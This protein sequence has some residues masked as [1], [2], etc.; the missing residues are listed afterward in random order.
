M[1]PKPTRIVLHPGFIKF[2]VS[3]MLATLVG[4]FAAVFFLQPWFHQGMALLDVSQRGLDATGTVIG[5]LM[6]YGAVAAATVLYGPFSRQEVVD[7][8]DSLTIDGERWSPDRVR[9]LASEREALAAART[10]LE[11]RMAAIAAELGKVPQV[12]E[13][14]RRQIAGAV[15]FTEES[16]S[17]VLQRLTAINTKTT[18]LTHFLLSSGAESDAIIQSARDRVQVNHTFVAQMER[19]VGAR[20]AEIEATREQFEQIMENSRAFGG[21]LKAIEIIAHQTNL[22]A[23]NAAIEA[24]RAGEAGK[25]FAVVA[26]EVR[27]LSHQ[28]AE[29]AAKIRTGL[30]ATD[31]I[32]NRFLVEHVDAQHSE[33]EIVTLESFGKQLMQAVQGYDELTGYLKNVIGAADSQSKVVHDLIL[34]AAA[35]VQ[36]Q[37]IVR[38]QLEHIAA[39]LTQLDLCTDGLAAPLRDPG[40]AAPILSVD[41]QL[42]D[43]MSRYVMRTQREAHAEVTGQA[44]AAK[45]DDIEL[46]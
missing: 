18:E 34:K 20:K 19:Y 39:A 22:L 32:I 7:H 13:V 31:A 6:A 30:D 26:G 36:F 5:I 23:L 33:A 35:N 45:T 28:T 10:D 27:G 15:D 8:G 4:A 24:Q 25:G 17:D 38:Q 12:H 44:V 9:A 11:L 40:T 37:D 2:Q 14:L 21:I 43:M 42:S 3:V 16:A 41:E 46:F 1:K 29:A